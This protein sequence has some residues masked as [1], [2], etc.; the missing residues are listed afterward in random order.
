[1]NICSKIILM[2]F[3]FTVVC[4]ACDIN[5][6]DNSEGPTDNFSRA[7]VQQGLALQSNEKS[8]IEKVVRS[9]AVSGKSKSLL[10]L[11]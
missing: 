1:M 8:N 5:P 2:G 11:I 4:V 3:I 7:Q 10:S 6:G 9:I